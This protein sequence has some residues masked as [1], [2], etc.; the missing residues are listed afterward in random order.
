VS[1][2]S[3]GA[4]RRKLDGD[5]VAKTRNVARY[6]AETPQVG[7]VAV[8]FTLLWGIYGYIITPK[9]K[10]PVVELRVAVAT[11]SWPGASAEKVEQLVTRKLEK[12]IGESQRIEKVESISRTGA[13]FVYVTLR[14]EVSNRAQEWED[15]QS[16]LDSIRD[17][18]EG[19]GPVQFQKDYS[20]T[21]T[22]M[23]TVASPPVSDIELEL[24]AADISRAVQAARRG[25][26]G[27]TR[28]TLVVNFAAD[29]DAVVIQRAGE[30][31]VRYLA[32]SP[33]I[34]DPRLFFG[35]SYFG[36]DVSTAVADDKLAAQFQEVMEQ[37]LRLSELQPEAW[38]PLLL[39][40]TT[41]TAER[42][43]RVAG[44]RYTY[45][46]LD[47]FTETIQRHLQTVPSVSRVVRSG[48]LPDQI[49]IE[50]SQAKFASLAQP[51]K[52]ATGP[53]TAALATKSA[54]IN[55][56]G[57][58]T[59][60]KLAGLIGARNVMGAGGQFEADGKNININ[61][62]GEFTDEN[63][64]GALVVTTSSDGSPVYLRDLVDV[65]RGYQTP[66]KFLNYLVVR[67]RAGQFRRLP[68][69]TLAVNMRAGEQTADFA[70]EVDA[71]L[72]SL[73][74]TLPEDLV[75]RRTS[76]Q[77]LQV[78]ENVELFLASLAEAILLVVIVTMVGFR[79]WR[80]AAVLALSILITLAMT[81]GMMHAAGVD[82]QQV[83]LASL[84]ISLGLLVDDPVVALD[85]IK[86]AMAQ[87]WKARI[88][89][90]LGPT[91][92]ASVILFATATNIVAYLP[93]LT[94]TGDT[95]KFIRTMPIV[96]GL[97][98]V[99]SRIVSMTFVPL[100]GAALLR[101][102][103]E[104]EPPQT[105]S[106]FSRTY[107]K[108]I[109]WAIGHRRHVYLA[110]AVV[111]LAAGAATSRMRTAFFPKDLSYLAYVDV[112][113][114]EDAPLT[115]TRTVVA[116]ATALTEKASED[117]SKIGAY[118]GDGVLSSVTEF[119]GGGG[120]R[121][122]FSIAP[123]QK[124]LNYAQ[125]VL[126]I[127]DKRDMP[128]F[129]AYLQEYLSR[130]IPG[131]RV[132]VRQ[133]ET[134][135]PVGVPVALRITGENVEQLRDYG[136]RAKAI[137]RNT[138]GAERVRDDWGSDTLSLRLDVD[139]D[140]AN[141][142]GITNSDVARSSNAAMTGLVVGHLREADR[143]INIV[144]RLRIDERAELSDVGGLYVSSQIA[145]HM[146]PL[147]QVSR[148]SFAT[149]PEKIRRKNQVRAITASCFPAAGLV[150]SEVLKAAA[151]RIEQLRTSLPPGY[152]LEWAGEAEQ[153]HKSFINL[154][155]VLVL[156]LLSL[157]LAL[158]IQLRHAVKPLIVLVTLPFGVL[159]ALA[160]LTVTRVPFGFMAFVG[161]ISLMGVIVSH[162]IVLFDV[163]EEMR[164]RGIP[165]RGALVEAGLM[166]LRPVLVTVVA[167]VLGLVPL[168]LH[169]G[170]LWEPLCYVQ[171][172]GLTFA[173]VITLVIVPCLY[174]TAAN[175]GWLKWTTDEVSEP[176]APEA[177]AVA[178][179]EREAPLAVAFA[180]EEEV[181]HARALEEG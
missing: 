110:G 154:T 162:I 78:R 52:G 48:V 115:A 155:R 33:G 27:G 64:L 166:R 84:I 174:A 140:R 21:A 130:R 112:W 122:W 34:E 76:D 163:I 96:L 105:T 10:D 100:L 158:V 181:Q 168:A 119:V 41:E 69:I 97:S 117:F 156:L 161:I 152:T 102:V 149:Q 79:E 93:F 129:T 131:A 142:A 36:V 137:L 40:D 19:A 50:Y 171:I 109:V 177:V 28:A 57:E 135:K 103:R 16:R 89:A 107:R 172:G 56:T 99:A 87:G 91:K 134:G 71:K 101:P 157:Y 22:L 80:S 173:T 61:A 94:V 17:L 45:H 176:S 62:T 165:I 37:R 1:I 104:E 65:S 169:G 30:T 151:P 24:R 9:A 95:G 2:D 31:A 49:F 25:A 75:I 59:L 29:V 167:T 7:W 121:F 88:A 13:A 85:A 60:S 43:G 120:P 86:Q 143:Q 132:D 153:R 179:P 90:W 77:P 148:I 12:K 15:I 175:R 127:K 133:L 113:L 139:E 164:M 92:L 138:P 144:A 145:G 116:Q 42:L 35:P 74:R 3:S 106:A 8:V 141:L 178:P 73:Q 70:K 58:V 38:E 18:P 72:S 26:D 66:P 170:P 63:D 118:A 6:F 124:Q 14:E 46:E 20:D 55:P 150:S 53:A 47:L 159:S 114:P 123:E 32:Q 136:E 108:V 160:I 126:Q 4:A 51:A 39:R 68:A 180:T 147:G 128:S 67:D 5:L 54:A 82:I 125:L 146:M 98:L 23:L 81:F 44:Q 111:L 11:C 83:S